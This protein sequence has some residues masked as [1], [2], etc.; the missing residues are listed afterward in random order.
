MRAGSSLCCDGLC[1]PIPKV[2]LHNCGDEGPL[3]ANDEYWVV[4]E[5]FPLGD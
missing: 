4:L 5:I 3:G 1:G 2:I